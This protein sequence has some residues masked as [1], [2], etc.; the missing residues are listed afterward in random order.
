MKCPRCQQDNPPQAKFCLECGTPL[1]A[2]TLGGPYAPS[3]AEVTSALSEILAQQTASGEILGVIARSPT[4]IQ[5]VLDTV[6]E[7]A[8][9][10]CDALDASIF[11]VDGNAF[12]LIAHHGA[13][14]RNY[15]ED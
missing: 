6:A 10:L 2:S 13:V 14:T 12:R 5:P 9:R 15:A 11:R 8:A 4:D 3:Y 1:R 7:S